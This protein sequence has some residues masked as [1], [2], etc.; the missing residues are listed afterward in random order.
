MRKIVRMLAVLSFGAMM[1]VPMWPAQAALERIDI[2]CTAYFVSLDTSGTRTWEAGNT[3]HAR[4]AVETNR[5]EGSPYCA[6]MEI[7]GPEGGF[8]GALVGTVWGTFR[9]EL[10]GPYSGS[11]FEGRWQMQ[12]NLA[13]Q[14][15]G[16][17]VGTGY[18]VFEGWQ[19][20][21]TFQILNG[22]AGPGDLYYLVWGYVFNPGG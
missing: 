13:T 10:T 5:T 4:T 9:Y 22:D 7:V 17:E 11:G 14:N 8:N 1:L 2:A 19:F 20:R 15:E 6:G 21:D 18:G 16:D 3:F 12:G